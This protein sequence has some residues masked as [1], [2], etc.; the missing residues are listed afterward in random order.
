MRIVEPNSDEN[1]GFIASM[2]P[3]ENEIVGYNPVNRIYQ[4]LQKKPV[5]AVISFYVLMNKF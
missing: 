4:G 1:E 2:H 5:S 3:E